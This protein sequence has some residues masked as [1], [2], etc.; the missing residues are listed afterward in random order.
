MIHFVIGTRAQLIKMAPV[1]YEYKKR[2][3]EYNFIFL[4]QHK[5]TMYEMMDMFGV[6]RPDFV[7]GDIGK[8]ITKAS[9]MIPW[10]VKVLFDLI[11]HRKKYFKDDN[12]GLAFVHGDAPPVLLGAIG[13]KL[14][15]KKIALIESGLRSHNWFNPFP[16]E[17]TRVLTWK[18]GLVDYHFCYDEV[19]YNNLRSY[20]GKVYN[21]L[22]N[23]MFD[24]QKLAIKFQDKAL[25]NLPEEMYSLVT[26]HRFETISNKTQFEKVLKILEEISK[27]IKL[28]FIMHPPTRVALKNFGFYKK[29]ED[30]SNIELRP[31]YL[32]FDFNKLMY[33]S[34]FIITDGGSNQEEA[35]YMGKP[36]CLFRKA[37]ERFEGLGENAVLSKFDKK[38]I[39]N[40]VKNYK[41]YRRPPLDSSHSP[42]KKIMEIIGDEY[43]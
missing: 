7:I 25:V 35:F 13:A 40:F 2:G 27:K 23:T 20:K 43:N 28:L 9:Q 5:E 36:C 8:D 41:S 22:H 16:E 38:L 39:M 1:M 12:R 24:A 29:L 14:T 37:T 6:K 19:S 4:A 31:R 34:E 18:L 10:S 3:I 15:G 32:F 30:N 26:I 33:N 21:V 17:I 42:V 11:I